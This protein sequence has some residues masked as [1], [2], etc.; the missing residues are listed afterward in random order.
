[1]TVIDDIA[2]PTIASLQA[3]L[4]KQQLLLSENQKVINAFE[5]QVAWL[6]ERLKLLVSKRYTHSS[7]KLNA[8]QGDFFDN[9]ELDA[10][11]SAIKDKLEDAAR[12]KPSGVDTASKAKNSQAPKDRPK[13]TALPAHP[14]GQDSCSLS[15]REF[16]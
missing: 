3:Q 5:D 15:L 4:A 16:L 10:E 7:E 13:R 11:I 2:E 14:L 8:L 6:E 9:S 12:T 1:M